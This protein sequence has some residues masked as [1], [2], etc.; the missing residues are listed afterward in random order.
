MQTI[1]LGKNAAYLGNN[2]IGQ[3]GFAYLCKQKWAKL[4]EIDLGNNFF[5][6][7]HNKINITGVQAMRRAF[8]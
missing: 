1:E 2:Q 3:A 4:K 7:G 5:N 8:G 6:K